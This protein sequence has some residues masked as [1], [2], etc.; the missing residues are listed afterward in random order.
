MK[1]KR[2]LSEWFWEVWCIIS[3]IGIWPRFIEPRFLKVKKLDLPIAGLPKELAGMKIV[4]LSDLHWNASFPQMLIKKVVKQIK[5]WKPD[6]IFFTG[7]WICKAHLEDADRLQQVLSSLKAQWGCFSVLGNHDYSSFVTLNSEGDYAI[8]SSQHSTAISKGFG[9]LFYPVRPS[10]KVDKQVQKVR[11]HSELSK[12]LEKTPFRILM[13]TTHLVPYKNT[14]VNISGLEEYMTGRLDPKKTFENF[15]HNYS[16]I[17]LCHNPDGIPKVESYPGQLILS[18]HTH[19]GQMNIPGFWQRFT[20]MENPE[21]KHG[22][23]KR[24]LKW[25][26]INRGLGSVMS[27]RWFARPELTLITL[28]EEKA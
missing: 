5:Q 4:H 13:N 17:L 25:I 1:K 15:D 27:F 6:F 23:I 18:G 11:P 21:F 26:Y 8:E 3:V 16:G 10:G 19:G 28:K 14:F 2:R 7:D 20:P 9:R 22:L 24:G 12:M